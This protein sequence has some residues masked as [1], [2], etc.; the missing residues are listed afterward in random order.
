MVVLIWDF[1]VLELLK[2]YFIT[3]FKSLDITDCECTHV[4]IRIFI[5]NLIHL[6]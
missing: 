3:T 2:D 6:S 5:L 4:H 1:N